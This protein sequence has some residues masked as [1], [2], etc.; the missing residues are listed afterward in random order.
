MIMSTELLEKIKE[1]AQTVLTEEAAELVD[2]LLSR[3]KG[4]LLIRFLVDKSFGRDQDKT[5]GITVDECARLNRR[6]AQVMEEKNIIQ[7]NYVLEVSSP[8]LDRPLVSTRDF[9]RCMGTVVRLVLRTPVNGENVL[10]GFLEDAD[11]YRVVIR[12]RENEKTV[13]ERKNIA[14]ARREI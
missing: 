1:T 12:G 13:V 2:L 9:Q 11:E 6:I 14:R 4:A 10:T 3:D 8:G 7:Q 5:G